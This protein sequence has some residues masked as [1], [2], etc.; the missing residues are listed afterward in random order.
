MNK[1]SIG[2][3]AQANEPAWL[4]LQTEF[5]AAAAAAAHDRFP[6]HGANQPIV[7]HFS[8]LARVGPLTYSRKC[9]SVLDKRVLSVS[10]LSVYN[11]WLERVRIDWCSGEGACSFAVSNTHDYITQS[12]T[13]YQTRL[14]AKFKHIIKRRKRKQKRFPK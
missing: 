7:P 4:L 3:S 12:S 13:S 11:R 8:Q 1:A 2:K 6:E 10:P 14:P 5:G 9:E